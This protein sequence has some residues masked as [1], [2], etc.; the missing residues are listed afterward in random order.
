MLS[1]TNSVYL[2]ASF[3]TEQK[4]NEES[5]CRTKPLLANLVLLGR[6]LLCGRGSLGFPLLKTLIHKVQR[7]LASDKTESIYKGTHHCSTRSNLPPV[8]S[9][10]TFNL[11]T[12]EAE[13][14]A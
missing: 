4:Q 8:S 14:K 5:K 7:T 2:Q 3:S 6:I 11:R 13:V 12:R 10:D 9:A 1:S